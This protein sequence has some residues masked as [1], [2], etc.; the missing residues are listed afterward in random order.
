MGRFETER[1]RGSRAAS[2]NGKERIT[3]LRRSGGEF[4]L[5]ASDSC[6]EA[7]VLP[8]EGVDVAARDQRPGPDIADD[9][10]EWVALAG[11][12]SLRVVTAPLIVSTRFPSSTYVRKAVVSAL[13]VAN[14]G[15]PH[16]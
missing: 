2:R 14:S 4:D 16:F 7:R 8:D 11:I 3:P 10:G 15:D 5:E 12:C 13:R 1:D 9:E 6:G